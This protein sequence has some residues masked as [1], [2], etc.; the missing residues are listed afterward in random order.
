MAERTTLP[1]KSRLMPFAKYCEDFAV[2]PETARR[3][4][5][6]IPGLAWRIGSRIFIDREAAEELYR[7]RPAWVGAEH[8]A[9]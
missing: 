2:H 5:R 9:A 3:Q 7:P 1:D 8:K 4:V 6:T